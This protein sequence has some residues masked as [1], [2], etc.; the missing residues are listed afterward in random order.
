MNSKNKINIVRDLDEEDISCPKSQQDFATDVLVGLSLSPKRL[1]CKYIYDK[2]G[3]QL[4]QKI[5]ALPEYY[6]TSCELEILAKHTDKIFQLIGQK[7][8]RLVELGAGDGKKAKI[9]LGE[10]MKQDL[11]FS[12]NPIDIS[13]SAIKELT[14]VLQNDIPEIYIEG[15]V[16]EYF[17]GLQWLASMDKKVNIVLFLGS[18]IGNFEPREADV[19]LS[20]LWNACND[21]DFLIIG[22]DLKKDIN[23]LVKAYNDSQG[24]TAQFIKNILN[25]INLELGGQFR[26]QQFK[27]FSTYNVVEGAIK[28]YLISLM[29]QKVCVDV[30]NREFTFTQWEPIHIESSYKYQVDKI[31][32][33]ARKNGFIV[34]EN[35][36]DSKRYFVDSLWRVEKDPTIKP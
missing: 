18:N 24:I 5:M 12:F 14:Q 20:N 13:N 36:F 25:R 30:L 9:I 32:I 33:L 7:A 6:L 22:F 17:K 16:S 26:P 29:D 27:Y 15:L 31:R 3:S 35:F 21:G 8:I 23:I 10:M 19:F 34:V 4:F 28:T 11:E 2:K 1:P